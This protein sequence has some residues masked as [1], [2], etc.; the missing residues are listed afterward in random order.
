MPARCCCEGRVRDTCARVPG[1]RGLCLRGAAVVVQRGH[2]RDAAAAQ[3]CLPA[4]PALPSHG[5]PQLHHQGEALL[6][7]AAGLHAILANLAALTLCLCFHPSSAAAT[8]A[9]TTFANVSYDYN[10]FLIN[11][12]LVTVLA[13]SLCLGRAGPVERSAAGRPGAF[14]PRG[15]S[16]NGRMCGVCSMGDVPRQV[17]ERVWLM[18]KMGGT[19]PGGRTAWVSLIGEFLG[20]H[21]LSLLVTPCPC[22]PPPQAAF[23]GSRYM[24]KIL[25]ISQWCCVALR[26]WTDDQKVGSSDPVL[27]DVTLRPVARSLV[28]LAAAAFPVIC[29]VG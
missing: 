11:N 10:G 15:R 23:S 27:S 9:Q 19:L 2:D 4:E 7:A 26:V 6:R 12:L 20:V 17:H 8:T 29:G 16:G 5:L 18:R 14:N 25:V 24:S 22:L 13:V 28:R 1:V 21:S 3:C